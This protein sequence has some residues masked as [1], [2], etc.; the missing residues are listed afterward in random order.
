MNS[1]RNDCVITAGIHCQ[2]AVGF[3]QYA[4]GFCQHAV[5]SRHTAVFT[6]RKSRVL[7]F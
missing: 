3:C 1:R 5:R 6:I 2:Y 7:K 4:V